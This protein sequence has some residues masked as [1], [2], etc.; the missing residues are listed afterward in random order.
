MT[1]IYFVRHAKSDFRI[2]NDRLRPLTEKG[3]ED[4]ELVTN[5]LC[6]Q[7]V[8][9]VLSS[10]YLRAVDTVKQLA[11]LKK[12]PIDRIEDFRERN[13]GQ[14]VH[15]FHTYTKQQWNDFRFKL[16]GGESLGE[17]QTRVIRVL[18][19]ILNEQDHH[20]LVIGSHGTALS[21]IINYY[22]P[23][24]G[25]TDFERMKQLMP[26]MVKMTFDHQLCK[27]IETIDLFQNKSDVRWVCS[28]AE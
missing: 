16:T 9:Q 19:Q 14:W 12:L 27:Q 22:D 18:N 17:V 2:H 10:P 4:R 15:D 3:I 28:P 20:V 25:F 21:T 7:H 11:D 5:Y 24:Y 8:D 26:W 23:P 1:T 13:V 6:N